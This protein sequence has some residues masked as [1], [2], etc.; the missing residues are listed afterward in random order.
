MTEIH[1]Q[2]ASAAREVARL[3]DNVDPERLDGR[4]PCPDYDIRGLMTHLMQEIVLHGWDLAVATGQSPAFPDDA[5]VTVLRW[6]D[7]G[8]EDMSLGR[9]YQA[10]VPTANVSALDRAVARSGRNPALLHQ[11]P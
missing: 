11:L 3:A 2:L 7:G 10:P 1:E 5:S 4:T 8:G 9:W 6:M